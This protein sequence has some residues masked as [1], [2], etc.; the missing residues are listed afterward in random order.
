MSA[1]VAAAITAIEAI[2][3]DLSVAIDSARPE[4]IAAFDALGL[5]Q[6]LF[7]VDVVTALDLEPSTPRVGDND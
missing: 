2:P 1:A 7:K 3:D 4:V 6:R 5:L